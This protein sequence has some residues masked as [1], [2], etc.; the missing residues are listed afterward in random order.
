MRRIISVSVR[1]ASTA[2]AASAPV[3][4]LLHLPDHLESVQSVV[5]R[6]RK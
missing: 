3:L 6:S 4:L 2:S 5:G 1:L